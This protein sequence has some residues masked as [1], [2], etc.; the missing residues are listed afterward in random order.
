VEGFTAEGILAIEAD[1]LRLVDAG[2]LAALTGSG[3]GTSR[4][5]PR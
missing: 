1:R 5:E 2:R 4:Q 3:E